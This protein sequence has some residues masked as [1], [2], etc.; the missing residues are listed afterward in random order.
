MK[1]IGDIDATGRRNGRPAFEIAL[2]HLKGKILNNDYP[3]NARV[4]QGTI[5]NELK[6]SR[7]PIREA[8]MRLEQEG[9]VRIVPRHGI[10]I[11]SLSPDDTRE[12]YE[13]LACLEPKAVALLASRRPTPDQIEP[14]VDACAAM[15]AALE[16][17]D[18]LAWAHADE[19]F[20]RCLA[21]LSGNSRLRAAIMGFW[22]QSHR[23]RMF[24]LRL[25]PKPVESTREHRAVVEAILAGDA[26]GAE[27]LYRLH[28]ER[29]QR[30][31]LE[32][33]ERHGF[34]RL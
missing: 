14:L 21:E 15:E 5:A 25:R 19:R 3:P 34:K 28:R 31:I 9:L 30:V 29:A 11:L 13:L 7:T 10:E 12:I 23:A 16:I 32:I 27:R 26:D 17:D 8:I 22:E 6:L 24:T 33:V 20:H 2:A 1:D 4:L 18:R